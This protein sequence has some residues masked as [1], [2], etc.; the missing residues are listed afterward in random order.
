MSEIRIRDEDGKIMVKYDRSWC[1][2]NDANEQLHLKVQSALR[3]QELVQGYHD[4]PDSLMTYNEPD[5]VWSFIVKILEQSQN[6]LG[7]KR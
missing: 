6:T 3:L 1:I 5:D 7:V 2:R 4:D